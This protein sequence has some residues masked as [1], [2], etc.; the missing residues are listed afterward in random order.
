MIAECLQAECSLNDLD[1]REMWDITD[2]LHPSI[3][4]RL[5]TYLYISADK[6]AKIQ[7]EYASPDHQAFWVL[8][9]WHDN[10]TKG[11]HNRI[12]LVTDLYN[13]DKKRLAEMVS[14]NRYVC[15]KK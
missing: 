12:K 2:F 10:T 11:A 4:P 15:S 13:L 5:A 9:T 6:V 3:V 7:K 8:K 1:E 14:L